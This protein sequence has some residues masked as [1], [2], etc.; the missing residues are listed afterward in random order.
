MRVDLPLTTGPMS[1]TEAMASPCASCASSP[2]CSYL[3]L[4]TFQMRTLVDLDM[5][6]Y[7]LNFD[8][9]ELGL[10]ANGN[11]SVYYRYPCRYLNRSDFSCTIHGTS[12]QPSTCVHYN[13]YQC[14]YRPA[15]GE[16]GGAEFLRVDRDRLR[17]IADRVQF[18]DAREIVVAPP[19]AELAEAFAA[20]P[21]ASGTEFGPAPLEDGHL[22][23][24][25]E[26]VRT[27]RLDPAVRRPLPLV[28]LHRSPCADCPSWCCTSLVFPVPV[29]GSLANLDFLRFA[30]GFPGVQLG[31][32]DDAWSLIVKTTC[33]H[34]VDGRC[35]VFG[36]AERPLR[37]RYY[38]EWNCTYRARLEPERPTDFLRITL[39]QYPALAASLTFDEYGVLMALPPVSE[40][41]ADVERALAAAGPVR[42]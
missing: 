38:N 42:R 27:G 24:W 6:T 3:P 1:F 18:N 15:L 30:L 31:I 7:L 23:R 12:Q 34:L 14:W 9:I 40:L 36:A 17:H 10:A 41:R 28:D 4:Q 13:P 20:L 16:P 25:D 19:W 33:R 21:I 37:C 11:W 26:Q 32:A 35:G 29:A 5:A 8:R 22:T 39:E 2:C